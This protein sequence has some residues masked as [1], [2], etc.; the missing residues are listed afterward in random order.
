VHVVRAG[1]LGKDIEED[2]TSDIPQVSFVM[3]TIEQWL[4]EWL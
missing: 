2:Q 1:W 3:D 4:P